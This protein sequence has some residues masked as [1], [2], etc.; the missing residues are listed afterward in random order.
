M[1]S[2]LIKGSWQSLSLILAFLP[3][4]T[5]VF[6][7]EKG[8]NSMRTSVV[9][10]S[11][12]DADFFKERWSGE[13][14]VGSLMHNFS[15]GKDEGTAAAVKLGSKVNYRL[16][17]WMRFKA[18]GEARF[19][20]GRIQT[21]YDDDVYDSFL[22]LR[23]GVVGIGDPELFEVQ[24]G[25]VNQSYLQNEL[26]VSRR[27]AFPGV[28]EEIVVGNKTA[29]FNFF[30][31]QVVP[32]SRSFNT[33]RAEREKTPTLLTETAK[34]TWV[35]QELF[36]TEVHVTHFRFNNLPSVIAF[37]S[38]QLGNSIRG[39]LA[40]E[41]QF[42]YSFEGFSLGT[43]FCLCLSGAMK[44]RVG[45]KWLQNSQAPTTA[46]RGQLL[47]LEPEIAWRDVAVRP[48][49]ST[50]FNESDTS[51]AAYNSSYLGNN[52]RKGILA[53]LVMEF[54]RY[55]FNIE[56]EYVQ[57]SLINNDPYQFDRQSVYLAVETHHVAF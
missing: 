41:S 8:S 52:N 6:A 55:G 50:F 26:L 35:P 24:I 20:G 15:E 30:A 37:E 1:G 21:R 27:R 43:E 33:E 31:Q 5:A 42:M 17:P 25:A 32:T 38:G 54:K 4:Y 36:E 2:V 19:Y 39:D 40:P 44:F 56:L 57:S 3:F 7:A 48:R 53:E 45:G 22:R 13:W 10:L 14:W 47:Y 16:T 51:P 12:D 46:N 28:K 29:K 9:S 23:E 34:L 18:E 11:Q 49:L